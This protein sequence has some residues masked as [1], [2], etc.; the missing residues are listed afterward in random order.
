MQDLADT[1]EDLAIDLKRARKLSSKPDH[2]EEDASATV[3]ADMQALTVEPKD[4]DETSQGVD[5]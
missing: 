2:C 3:S 1:D 5:S 4:P